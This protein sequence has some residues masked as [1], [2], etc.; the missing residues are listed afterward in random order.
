MEILIFIIFFNSKNNSSNHNSEFNNSES[1]NSE[2]HM[3][4]MQYNPN[5]KLNN[6]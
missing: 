1:N 3:V 4:L 5:M 2:A 6:V